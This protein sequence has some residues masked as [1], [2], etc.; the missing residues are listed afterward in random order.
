MRKVIL[1]ILISLLYLYPTIVVSQSKDTEVPPGM[2]IIQIG[3]VNVLVP[4]GIKVRKEGG[5]VILE[6][7]RD[8][9]AR[10][11]LDMEERL[12]EIKA[13]QEK[14]RGEVEDLEKVLK[15]IQKEK[16]VSNE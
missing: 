9:V 13:R 2:E 4:K 16:S 1:A 5:L 7:I 11:L 10:R 6:N 15:E 14:L 8:Y 12:A 3:K